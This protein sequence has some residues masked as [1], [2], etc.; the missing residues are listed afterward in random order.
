MNTI[1][2]FGIPCLK[3]GSG[4]HIKKKNKGKFTKYCNGKVTQKCIDEAKRSGNP[5]LVK[6]ATFAQNSRSWKHEDGGNVHKP[7]GHR[8]VLDNGW[9]NTKELKKKRKLVSFN[10]TGTFKRGIQPSRNWDKTMV[11]KLI[12]YSENPDSVGWD[13]KTKRWY[14]PP[15]NKG[16]D[17]NQFGMGVDRN[18]TPGFKELVKKD[19]KGKE[20]LTESDERLLRHLAIDSAN[21][22]ANKRYKYAQKASKT[23]QFISPKHDAI[24]ISAIYNLGPGRV[25]R[26]IFENPKAMKAIFNRNSPQYQK[27][28]HQQYKLKGRNKRIENELNFFNK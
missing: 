25:A 12:N 3:K 18:Q 5:T 1:E 20:Y 28:V 13:E 23:K 15:A 26:T 22:S 6:R 16:Y 11:G 17:T 7:N 14:A 4:I 19:S 27:F 2:I 10:Q 8:S 21:D 9:I 24:T